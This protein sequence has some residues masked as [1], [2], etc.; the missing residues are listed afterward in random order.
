MRSRQQS[1][2]SLGL[3]SCPVAYQSISAQ[4]MRENM[5]ALEPFS[6]YICHVRHQPVLGMLLAEHTQLAGCRQLWSCSNGEYT[7]FL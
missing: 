2:A 4:L 1:F 7:S 6:C 5:F 3:A